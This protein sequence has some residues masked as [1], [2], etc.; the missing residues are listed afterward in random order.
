MVNGTLSPLN[1]LS[2]RGTRRWILASACWMV[3]ASLVPTVHAQGEGNAEDV[4]PRQETLIAKDGF[5]IATTYWPT[6]QK[7]EGGVVVLLHALNGNQLDW[8]TLPKQLQD[9]GYA[10]IAV[11]LRGHGQSKGAAEEVETKPAKGKSKPAKTGKATLEAASLRARDF[12]AM[13]LLDMEAVKSFI[14][15]EHQKQKLNMNKMAIV[16]AGMG[17][18]VALK[19]AAVDW[20]KAPHSDGPVGNRTPRGQDIRALVLLTPDSEVSGLPLPDAI[21]TLRVPPFQIGMMFGYGTKDKMD[22]GQTKKLYDQAVSV[23]S[24]EKRM[25]LQEYNTALR[26]SA[27][28]GKGLNVEVNIATFLKKHLQELNSEWRN[29]ESRVGKKKSS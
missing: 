25:Y 28:L 11:D 12:E 21:K 24:N 16:G 4:K 7:Q 15:S 1:W 10:V 17:A 8:G 5:R 3:L 18:A 13:V 27:M 2:T 9:E 6:G 29:R 23:E 26:G 14:Y 19:Y 22:K 20:T